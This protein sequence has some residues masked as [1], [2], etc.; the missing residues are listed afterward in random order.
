MVQ[1]VCEFELGIDKVVARVDIAV[2]FRGERATAG[3]GEKAKV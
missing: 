2:A 1:E 3:F